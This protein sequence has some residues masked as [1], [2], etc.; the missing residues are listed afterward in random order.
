MALCLCMPRLVLATI[1]V[2]IAG[3]ASSAAATGLVEV[4]HA[5]FTSCAAR[6]VIS[7]LPIHALVHNHHEDTGFFG[8]ALHDGQFP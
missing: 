2:I 1:A 4:W 8:E 5:L 3:D 7:G 6:A